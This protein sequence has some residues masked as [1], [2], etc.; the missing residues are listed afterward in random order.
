MVSQATYKV[1]T[2]GAF[3]K[4]CSLLVFSHLFLLLRSESA[5]ARL[6]PFLETSVNDLAREHG[7]GLQQEFFLLSPQSSLVFSLTHPAQSYK[8]TACTGFNR[9]LDAP[10]SAK[11]KNKDKMA[12][13]QLPVTFP[14]SFLATP[15]FASSFFHNST[16]SLPAVICFFPRQD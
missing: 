1:H 14:I 7:Q 16:K 11:K 9:I 10:T 5:C 13:R 8:L 12:K 3:G 15:M 2:Q 6:S 4:L